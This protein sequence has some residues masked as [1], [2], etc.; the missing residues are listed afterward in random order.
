MQWQI[1][2]CLATLFSSTVLICSSIIIFQRGTCTDRCVLYEVIR[3]SSVRYCAVVLDRLFIRLVSWWCFH[4]RVF[5]SLRFHLQSSPGAA[6]NL[7][8]S[9]HKAP[10]TLEILTFL[11]LLGPEYT[12]PYTFKGSNIQFLV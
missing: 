8:S 9:T 5:A 7:Q 3:N 12:L 6:F 4:C 1:P 2:I 11:N 10:L